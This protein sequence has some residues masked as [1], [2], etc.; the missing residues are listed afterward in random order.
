MDEYKKYLN[1]IEQIKILLLGIGILL[2]SICNYIVGY[3]T[4]ANMYM[5]LGLFMEIVGVI[6]LLIGFFKKHSS[7]STKKK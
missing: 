3:T 5:F 7:E 6:I 1:I 4:D 2:F